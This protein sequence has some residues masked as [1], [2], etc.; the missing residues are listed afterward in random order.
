KDGIPYRKFLEAAAKRGHPESIRKLEGPPVPAALA[1]LWEYFS[2]LEM[3]R[4]VGMNGREPL[5]YESIDA[6]SRLLDHRV[7][8]HEVRALMLLDQV[9]RHPDSFK[10]ENQ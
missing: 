7:R 5:T 2:E 6:W 10:E 9:L 8:P 4:R 1:Y 3:G